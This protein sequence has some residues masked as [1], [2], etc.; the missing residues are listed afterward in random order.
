MW[1]RR[2][3]Y[4]LSCQ[5]CHLSQHDIEQGLKNGAI[6]SSAGVK[7]YARWRRMAAISLSFL[8]K[9]V[10]SKNWRMLGMQLLHALE[11][12][13]LP[14][15]VKAAPPHAGDGGAGGSSD[16]LVTMAW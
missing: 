8:D 2:V 10:Y 15:S 13:Q 16:G 4:R 12:R 7:V 14:A 9:G 1:A 11:N 6:A 5:G 3:Q